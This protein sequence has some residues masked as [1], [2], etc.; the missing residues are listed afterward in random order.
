MNAVY[1][2]QINR[3][4]KPGMT[5]INEHLRFFTLALLNGVPYKK[6]LNKR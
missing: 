6:F 2:Y 3:N 5:R 1:L 4:K